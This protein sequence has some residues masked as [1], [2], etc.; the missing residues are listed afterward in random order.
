MTPEREFCETLM[1]ADT[2]AEVIAV[3]EEAGY[4][5]DTAVWRHLGDVENNYSIVGNQQS[6]AIAA[7]VEKII[8]GVDSRLLDACLLGAIDPTG[9]KAPETIRG[10]VAEF[11]DEGD[12]KSE[13]AGRI[14]HWPDDKSRH[15]GRLLTI[16]ATGN[17]PEQGAPS[18]S[19]ADGGEGQ[20]PDAFPTT[21]MS[22]A[23]SNK[24]RIPFV[25]GK[26]NMG[27]TGALGF[28]G[29]SGLQLIVSRRNPALLDVGASARDH[30]W[31]FT[32][33]RREPP[34]G[35]QR[36]SVYT[37]LAPV[38]ATDRD[39]GVLSFPAEQ[40]AIFPDDTAK[41]RGAYLR[42]TTHGALVKL[43]EYTWNGTKS[44]VVSS[45]EGLLRRLDQ[46]LPELALPARIY[47]CRAYGG[48]AGS[49]ST[50]LLG[51]S[52]RLERDR[53]GK[54]EAGF[55]TGS[56]LAVNGSKVRAHIYAFKKGEATGYRTWRNAVIF[57]VNGQA[58]AS[59]PADFLTRRRV[60]MGY[61]RESLLV[62]L[63]CS[64]IEGQ[65]RED[66]FMNSRDRLRENPMS[67]QITEALETVLHDHPALRELQNRRRQED[68]DERLS[69]DKPLADAL[70]GILKSNPTLAKLFLDGTNI[71][72]PFP[73]KGTGTGE[74]PFDGKTY[75][76]FFRF[77]G[78]HDG[79]KLTRDGHLGSR[80]R[81]QLETDA[82]NEYFIRDL[83][84]GEYSVY[85]L[86]RDHPE[87]MSGCSITS[88]HDG[89]ATLVAELPADAVVGSEL[90]LE[91]EVLDP[92][93]FD[94][95]TNR[96]I[97]R[98]KSPGA[99]SGGPHKPPKG[100]GGLA[101]PKIKEVHENEWN[102]YSFHTFTE[103]DALVVVQAGDDVYDFYVN[104]DNKFLRTA[105][106]DFP[107]DNP[108]M[109]T[110]K[111]V[112]ANVLFGLAMLNGRTQDTSSRD[113]KDDDAGPEAEVARVSAQLAPVM[114]PMIDVVAS[115]S[116]D[117]LLDDDA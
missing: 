47:E 103:S 51:L 99:P 57:T 69:D 97:V 24:F 27:G 6:D 87:L 41:G 40:L 93:R 13:R 75:P 98:V 36:S 34:Q 104:V 3:L 62:I 95:F 111:F 74:G 73:R 22:L 38:N 15:E 7:M 102:D 46:A 63:D 10:A 20:V 25:Q 21:F 68:I 12:K 11:F 53:A 90:V 106:K 28:C 50:N 109:M 82:E 19:V 30:E 31:G 4:W 83:D 29:R 96:L 1:R 107:K 54:L 37:Y 42:E 89:I 81:V 14:A 49:Y 67:K 105:H 110:A 92:S 23:K 64:D 45:G 76:T 16:A 115:L 66:L 39:G 5:D 71:S 58:H 72:A 43:Y 70:S 60:G 8:N 65:A 32:V 2:E 18:I 114:L 84:P 33:V 44:N 88:L 35:N 101:L 80:I 77:K 86:D 116:P 85:R 112:Y 9:P 61:L 91:I 94:P 79:E 55:P 48:H 78:K 100:N 113:G 117:D 26:F 108:K 59:L 52:A 56:I 17:M